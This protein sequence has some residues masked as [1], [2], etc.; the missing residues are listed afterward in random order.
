MTLLANLQSLITSQ[1]T[2]VKDIRNALSGVSTNDASAIAAALDT[3]AGNLVGAVNELNGNVESRA[4]AALLAGYVAAEGTVSP[5]D[6]VISAIQKLD[7]NI[8]AIVPG[9]EIDDANPSAS[10][11]Y[12]G[13]KIDGDIAAAVAS[14]VNAAPGALDQLNELASAIGNDAD[15][16]STVSNALALKANTADVY[17]QT[18]LGAL[19]DTHDFVAD[20]TTAIA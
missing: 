20:W 14:L 11:T 7:G 4:I 6:S 15:Y 17:T 16:A 19:L 9:A 5:T 1:G 8:A 10:T 3:T 2:T 18:Q 13:T 12:S